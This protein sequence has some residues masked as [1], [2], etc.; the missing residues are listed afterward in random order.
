MAMF[1]LRLPSEMRS[2]LIAKD[3]KDCTLL[4]E[5]ADLLKSSRASCTIAGVNM[6]YEA[7]I[8]AVSGSRHR[9]FS[10]HD[11]RREK[12]VPEMPRVQPPEDPQAAQ[13]GQ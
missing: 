5:Y 10:P 1:L 4:E 2:H 3:F 11:Q 6:E 7:A 9:E 12:S 13:G 8:S